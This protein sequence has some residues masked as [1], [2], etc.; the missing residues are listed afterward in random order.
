MEGI[1]GIIIKRFAI[2]KLSFPF[3]SLNINLFVINIT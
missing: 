3:H 1:N 2:R